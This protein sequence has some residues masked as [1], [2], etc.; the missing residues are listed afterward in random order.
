M[1]TGLSHET[2]YIKYMIHVAQSMRS[3]L[4]AVAVPGRVGMEECSLDLFN[5]N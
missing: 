5:L 1:K 2:H 4:N 3:F